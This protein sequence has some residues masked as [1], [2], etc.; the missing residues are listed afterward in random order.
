MSRVNVFN[1]SHTLAN[2]PLICVICLRV[3]AFF[4]YILILYLG[5]CVLIRGALGWR[6]LETQT[7]RNC[8][9]A[10]GSMSLESKPP[11]GLRPSASSKDVVSWLFFF[12]IYNV[13]EARLAG[14]CWRRGPPA[15]AAVQ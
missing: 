2:V 6:L 10:A 12:F 5:G 9:G 11:G 14:D 15:T 7:P 4:Y 3:Y 8:Y 1:N 13:L